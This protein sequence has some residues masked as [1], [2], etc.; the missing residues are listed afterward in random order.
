MRDA[1]ELLHATSDARLE[2]LIGEAETYKLETKKSAIVLKSWQERMG[3][4]EIEETGEEVDEE[5]E[6]LDEDEEFEV[7]KKKSLELEIR[8]LMSQFAKVQE[9]LD[10]D[11]NGLGRAFDT[12]SST[13][14][15]LDA[16]VQKL[17]GD[18]TEN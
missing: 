2:E 13:M 1:I 5:M 12:V 18:A 16:K 10:S 6:L 4:E 7:L 15:R 11:E 17:G 3:P 14:S 9:E 8:N